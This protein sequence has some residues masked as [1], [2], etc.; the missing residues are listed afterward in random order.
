MLGTFVG[1]V[2]VKPVACCVI[3]AVNDA[4]CVTPVVFP[5]GPVDSYTAA[6]LF[7]VALDWLIEHDWPNPVVL[8]HAALFGF[9]GG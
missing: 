5:F 8:M 6:M 1:L 9:V 2:L 4:V 7:L 3:E